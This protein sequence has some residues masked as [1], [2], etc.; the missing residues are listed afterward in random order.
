MMLFPV[1]IECTKY[2]LLVAIGFTIA[3]IGR[4][5]AVP[6]SIACIGAMTDLLFPVNIHYFQ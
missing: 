2:L 3:V 5:F 1:S 6:V 4:F